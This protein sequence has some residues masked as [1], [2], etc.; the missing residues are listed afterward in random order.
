M[1]R[2][3]LFILPVLAV[4]CLSL[5]CSSSNGA[6][7]AVAS[8]GGGQGDGSADAFV[9]NASDASTSG[10]SCDAMYLGMCEGYCGS[11]TSGYRNCDRC[12]SISSE[13]CSAALACSTPDDG[14]VNDAGRTRCEQLLACVQSCAQAG[15]EAGVTTTSCENT[16]KLSYNL[17]EYEQYQ[18]LVS[19]IASFC[20]YDCP[21]STQ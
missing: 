18:E 2:M 5:A 13:A 20:P 3:N 4:A 8:D 1:K 12:I 11:Y 7:A 16:C 17:A 10:G 14:G 9:P 6:Q 21:V 19:F 15:A